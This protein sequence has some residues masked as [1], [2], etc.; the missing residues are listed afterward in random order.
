MGIEL[1][2]VGTARQSGQHEGAGFTILELLV[3]MAVTLIVMAA[4][5]QLFS[6]QQRM[7]NAQQELV[8]MQQNLRIN[9]II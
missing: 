1:N 2:H 7:H 4:V 6:S 5:F 8:R 3:G 9:C